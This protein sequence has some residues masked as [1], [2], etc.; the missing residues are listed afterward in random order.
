[1]KESKLGWIE[2]QTHRRK[3]GREEVRKGGKRKEERKER[4][5]EIQ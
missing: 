4:R 5:K 2:G 3:L 1:M